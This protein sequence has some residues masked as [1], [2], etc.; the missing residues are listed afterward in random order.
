MLLY[1]IL[2]VTVNLLKTIVGGIIMKAF[3]LKPIKKLKIPEFDI[4]KVASEKYNEISDE[5]DSISHNV[6]PIDSYKLYLY[7]KGI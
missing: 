1:I 2:I 3:V 5:L 4:L 7:S 6:E